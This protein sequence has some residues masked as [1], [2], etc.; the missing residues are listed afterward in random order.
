MFDTWWSSFW[1][2]IISFEFEFEF[3]SAISTR[4]SRETKLAL[5]FKL[6]V[7]CQKSV[8]MTELLLE[9][10]LLLSCGG[11]SPAVAVWMVSFSSPQ[12]LGE[13]SVSVSCC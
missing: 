1:A 3:E 13:E 11:D 10:T 7:E 6:R 4:L 9:A 2:F 5:F 8:A 12:H